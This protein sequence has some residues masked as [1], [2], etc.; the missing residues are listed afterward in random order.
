[1]RSL[2]T[3][4]VSNELFTKKRKKGYQYQNGTAY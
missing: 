3:Y 4:S 1:M 2:S